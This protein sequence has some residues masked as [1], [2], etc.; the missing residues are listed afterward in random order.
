MRAGRI[1]ECADVTTI[2]RAPTHAYTQALVRVAPRSA[3]TDI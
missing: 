1:V 2:L 3:G